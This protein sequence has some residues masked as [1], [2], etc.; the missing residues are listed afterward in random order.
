MKPINRDLPPLNALRSFEAAAR[1]LSFT[2]AAE[3]LSVTQGAISR[4][5]KLLEEH[6]RCTLFVRKTRELALTPAGYQLLPK[7]TKMLDE[8]AAISKQLRNPESNELKIKV[9]PTFAI[10]WLL[11]RM[12]QFELQ[13][14]DIPLRVTTSW[15]TSDSD[16]ELDLEYYDLVLHSGHF[17]FKSRYAEFIRDE[18]IVPVCAPG[19]IS[20]ENPLANFED[21]A[22]AT[23]IHPTLAHEDWKRWLG[24][25]GLPHINADNGLDFDTLDMAI[26]AAVAGHGITVA[27]SILIKDELDAGRLVIPFNQPVKS[28]FAYGILIRPEKRNLHKVA[29]FRNWLLS[30]V[31]QDEKE[32]IVT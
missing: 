19:Y 26:T 32:I 25:L 24:E 5:V 15:Q 27:D 12:K 7:L 31:Q 11:P 21:L 1:H 22:R 20:N 9:S 13:N 2:L 10:R 8:L 29:R 23:L 28:Q 6:L 17:P 18:S 30:E 16:E 3:E 14:P 4:Q